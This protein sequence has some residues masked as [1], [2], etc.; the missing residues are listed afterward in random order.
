MRPLIAFGE[1][2]RIQAGV[3]LRGGYEPE[4]QNQKNTPMYPNAL[5]CRCMSRWAFAR[6]SCTAARRMRA[7]RAECECVGEV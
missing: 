5:R 3:K 4:T 6:G 1:Q 2:L 7:P